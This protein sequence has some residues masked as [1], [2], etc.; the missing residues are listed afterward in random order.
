MTNFQSSITKIK[1]YLQP[2]IDRWH[3]FRHIYPNAS[4]LIKYVGLL[5]GA[6]ITSI[7]LLFFLVRIGI[8]GRIP[9]Q[10]D[11]AA[12]QNYT[13][14]EVY[15]ADSVLLG[16]Y[17]I[18]N[19][20]V[21]DYDDIS[22]DIVNAL[23]AT[24][25]ARFF[26]HRGVDLRAWGRVL[27]KTVLLSRTSSGGGST[28]SQQ[29]AKNLFPRRN[30]WILTIPVN[31][32]KEMYVA[33]RLEKVYSKDE[34]ISLYLNTVPF[35]GNM[36]GVEVAAKQLF[37]S[38]AK[39]IQ[40]ENAATLVG[41]LK[42]NTYYSPIRHPERA[43]KR[44]NVVLSQMAKYGY[45]EAQKVDSLQQ[46]PLEV[47]VERPSNQEGLAT[48]F[49]EHLRQEL[50]ESIQ[51]YTRP[52]GTPYNLYTDGL[53]IYTTIDAKMQQYAEEAVKE[54]LAKL[55]KDFN[56]H[57]KGRKPWGND[58]ILQREMRKSQRY[59]SLKASGATE[60]AILDQF[61]QAIPMRVFSWDGKATEKEM[62]PLDSIKYY[63]TLLN[64]GFLVMEPGTGD[65]KAWVGGID[66][67]YF[68]YDHV[69][70]RRQVG[71]TF[72]PIVYASAIKNGFRPCDYYFNRLVTYTEY[73]DWQP[74][75]SDGQYGGLYSMQGA[76]SKSVNSVAVDLIVRNGIDSVRQ[77]AQ[78]MGI[79]SEIPNAPSIAL[80]T[81]DV[82]LYDMLKVYGSL[83][84]RGKRPEPRYISRIE[85][86][87]GTIVAVFESQPKQFERVL[88]INEAD[89]IRQM[90]QTVVDSG[91]A[92][93]IR[94]Q[95]GIYTPIAGKTGT[96]QSH[97]D[98]W[99]IGFT[100]RLVAG[101]WVGGE[102]P[103][104]RFRSIRLGQGANT[105]LPIW[106]R[107]MKKIYADKA[108]KR[109]KYDAFANPSP[110]V[111]EALDCE[112]FYEDEMALAQD[113]TSG[114]GFQTALDALLDVFKKKEKRA[115]NVNPRTI[116]I[117]QQK[118][119]EREAI[120]KKN[121]KI[122]KKRE[123]KKKRKEAWDKLFKK[124]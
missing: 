124:N 43:Q 86:S 123:R 109:L 41:M 100:P 78:Q 84:N 49:R 95:Y 24:E 82:S 50:A 60:E 62:S 75:N 67:K 25:D 1:A 34:L 21:V 121:E 44:R 59:Q 9:S 110:E 68:K 27:I 79:T 65:I 36:F 22:P 106:A 80:G 42:A 108:F 52:D 46:L 116:I 4:L 101:A 91:T 87:D 97:A 37:N 51:A 38:T 7:L 26:E 112:P 119:K 98:G 115:V 15:S 73:E 71:S 63:Y 111:V 23:I 20:K 102:Y 66:Y 70:S 69:K 10:Q 81:A 118:Q 11:L 54:H 107:F 72:K 31:K 104:I 47:Q 117:Q 120:R 5:F 45:L 13:A 6:G 29:L 14:S 48:Y 3:R 74:H 103:D 39:H 18:E 53:R 35:G 19:R 122:R 8:F 90:M 28:L 58:K 89:M 55:Q 105:A 96:T 113:T 99:F 2:A 12:I 93:R 17:Y 94:Y 83:A 32:I 30:Y 76:L 88:S 64:A 61:N 85:Q 77:L 92:R 114:D 57:W 40:T 16:K 56:T 33:R